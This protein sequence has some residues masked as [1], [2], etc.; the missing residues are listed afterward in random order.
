MK[1]GSLYK[2][3]SL[4]TL[5]ALC[6]T[7]A[8]GHEFDE[9]PGHVRH[10][11]QRPGHMTAAATA[12]S[13]SRFSLRSAHAPGLCLAANGGASTDGTRVVLAPCN[14]GSRAQ[15]WQRQGETLRLFNDMCLDVIN[16]RDRDGTHLQIWTCGQDNGNQQ[17]STDN[18]VLQWKD[19]TRCAGLFE[20]TLSAGDAPQMWGCHFKLPAQQWRLQA[21]ARGTVATPHPPA[22]SVPATPVTTQPSASAPMAAAVTCQGLGPWPSASAAFEAEVLTL[23]NAQRAQGAS[24]GASGRFAAQPALT[25]SDKL[26]CLARAFA[27]D[28]ADKHYFSH[29]DPSGRSPF[30]RMLAAGVSYRAAAENIAEGQRTPQEVVDAWMKSA[31]HCANIMGPYKS[32]GTG[33]YND[34]WVQD[35]ATLR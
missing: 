27:K 16:G 28:M 15:T 20:D 23:I 24:C 25:A 6:G 29:T 14:D 10:G 21:A 31:G 8:C 3:M 4:A 17:W 32:V 12:A 9:H 19:H 26:T 22:T 1:N 13:A 33:F 5:A 35:F 7:A 18:G 34:T 11:S 30:D 2:M